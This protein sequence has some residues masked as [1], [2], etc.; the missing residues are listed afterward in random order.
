MCDNSQRRESESKRRGS[1]C[2]SNFQW[3]KRAGES[4]YLIC[5][6]CIRYRVWLHTCSRRSSSLLYSLRLGL[7]IGKP[8][9]APRTNM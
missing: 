2:L 9:N 4:I 5:S 1:F 3:A 8:G 7:H 6:V